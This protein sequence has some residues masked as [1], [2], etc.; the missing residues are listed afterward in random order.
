VDRTQIERRDFPVGPRGYDP[1]AVDAHL[2]GVADELE[3]LAGG[4]TPPVASAPEHVRLIVEVAEASAAA[5]QADADRRAG[6][7]VA[8][9]REAAAGMLSRI[10]DLDDEVT[11]LLVALRRSGERLAAGLE[12]LDEEVAGG[13][14]ATGDGPPVAADPGEP[15]VNGED[16]AAAAPV[17]PADEAGARLTALHMA[18]AGRPRAEAA[19]HLAAHYVLPD[20]D[21]LLDDVYARAGR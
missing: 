4:S 8:R 15:P 1:A 17:P 18:L 13:L 11:T 9:V 14:A 2:R 19:A 10:E 20:A 7:H 12:R 5:L 3:R 16:Y 6:A 21:G